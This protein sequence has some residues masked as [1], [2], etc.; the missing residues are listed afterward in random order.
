MVLSVFWGFGSNP[1][2]NLSL[3][4]ALIFLLHLGTRPSKM[5]EELL[6]YYLYYEEELFYLDVRPQLF[7]RSFIIFLV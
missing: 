2:N 5:G 3:C 4:R 6:Y 7:K 1:Q